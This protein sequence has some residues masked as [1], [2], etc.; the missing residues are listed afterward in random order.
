M[1]EK[2]T[3]PLHYL[4]DE[5]DHAIFLRRM[6]EIDSQE[7]SM[8]ESHRDDHCNFFFLEKGLS[9]F[10]V[11]FREVSIEGRGAFCILPG[12]V[13]QPL[14]IVGASGW[15]MATDLSSLDDNQR[16]VFENFVSNGVPASVN[17]L[18]SELL[19]K[20]L[21]LLSDITENRKIPAYQAVQ[22]SMLQVCL[23]MFAAI[24][25]EQKQSDPLDNLR[26]AII[27]RQF[28][29]RL[30][31][32]FKT[33]KSPFEYAHLLNITPSY[34]NESVKSTTGL[35]VSYWIH[36]EVTMEAKR[37]LYYTDLSIKE[38]SFSLGYEDHTYFSRLFKKITQ[39]SPGQFRN[40][41]RK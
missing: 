11:D 25:Q 37:L 1:S 7:A 16:S 12:Q 9:R 39:C 33:L 26:P 21:E 13:H 8:M 27:T 4:K 40:N 19:G 35:P 10:M 29:S 34:L 31:K 3:I 14:S 24:F 2:S 15:F 30:L 22:N 18:Q 20:C 17:D 38:I 28:K 41:Y 36:Q 6:D 5:T 32:D 23:G